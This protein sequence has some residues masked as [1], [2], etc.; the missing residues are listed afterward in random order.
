MARQPEMVAAAE[1]L[2]AWIHSQRATWPH[3]APLGTAGSFAAAAAGATSLT[4]FP[5]RVEDDFV[6][7]TPAPAVIPEASTRRAPGGEWLARA[8]GWTT[9]VQW[10]ALARSSAKPAAA[11]AVV[12]M[13]AGVAAWG[14]G[15]VTK[16]RASSAKAAAAVEPVA[17]TAL[18]AKAADAPSGPAPAAKEASNPSRNTD[19]PVGA[20][21]TAKPD[22]VQTGSSKAPG[23]ASAPRVGTLQVETNPPGAKVVIDGRDRGVTPVT[24]DDLS[25]GAHNVVLESDQG[26]LRRTVQI[27]GGE[28]EVLNDSIFSGWL[29]VAAPVD[30]VV[31]EKGKPLQMDARRQV[32]LKAGDHE[33]LIESR[34]FGFSE[35]RRVSI[36]PGARTTVDVEMGTSTLSVTASAV[37][38]VQVDGARVGSTP[39][40]DF[41]LKMGTHDVVVTD[42]FGNTRRRSLRVTSAPARLEI[43]F[44]RP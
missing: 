26:T 7:E 25:P 31:S 10:G 5:L 44:T 9:V 30:V 20:S 2:R 8:R 36:E 42:I 23:A 21:Q 29:H 24:L 6:E 37:A 28:I 14:R 18:D 33:L 27:A 15:A 32:L 39:L 35:V 34:A 17:T 11:A 13:L 41:P 19:V 38:Q 40:L 12:L 16:Y 3:R 43:D 4:A 22:V 1:A